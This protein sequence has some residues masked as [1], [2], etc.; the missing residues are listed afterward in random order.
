MKKCA[1]AIYAK[2]D[3]HEPFKAN[4]IHGINKHVPQADIVDLGTLKAWH[5]LECLPD[6]DRPF[7]MRME[8]PLIDELRRYDRVVWVDVDV[9]ILS[10]GFSGILEVETSNDGLAAVSDIDNE[11]RI[12]YMKGLSPEY[13]KTTYFNSG[14][15]VFDLNKINPEEWKRKVLDGIEWW[16]S[17][18]H[19]FHDQ[20]VFNYAFEI[21]EID[22]KYNSI[23]RVSDDASTCIHY[24]DTEG[25][26]RLSHKISKRNAWAKRCIVL[27]PRHDFIRP[28]IR[29]Y[30]ASGNDTPLVIVPGPPG[31]WK[32]GDMEYCE[33]AAEFSG[34]MV[35]DCSSEWKRAECLSERAAR[36]KGGTPVG[37][38]SKK[39]IL[40]AVATKLSPVEWA[41]IDD[42]AEVTGRLDED[43]EAVISNYKE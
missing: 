14:V 20:D 9:D 2:G 43:Y 37:W 12:E 36:S 40:H 41:W 1:F 29:S 23:W 16:M 17:G 22:K 27:A 32:P 33:A 28:W 30:F 3:R 4:V 26:K 38:Y 39:C 10:D 11:R 19:T 21:N 8:I 15:M 5:L 7:F 18:E 42:D 35:F 25:K 6:K 24:C 34:G 31:D 13:H